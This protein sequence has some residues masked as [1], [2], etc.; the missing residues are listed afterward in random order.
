[1]AEE[2]RKI[3]RLMRKDLPGEVPVEA[4]LRSLRGVGF[5]TAKAIR[6]KVGYDSKIMMGDLTDEE[7]KTLEKMLE[8]PHT[9]EFPSWML[10]RRKDPETG[11]DTHLVETNLMLAH[12]EDT[13]KMKKM[14]SYRGVRHMFNL[15]VRGQ[16][17][18]STG[19]KNKTIGVQRKKAGGVK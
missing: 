5:M 18:R 13:G 9:F 17:T 16:R 2:T 8:E 15:A 11:I 4:A 6:K 1:M 19:R 3:V 14:K 12:R 7:M 10:N